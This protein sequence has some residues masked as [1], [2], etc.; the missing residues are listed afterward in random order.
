MAEQENQ[1]Q[2]H[3]PVSEQ[4]LTNI[5][6]DYDTNGMPPH[7]FWLCFQNSSP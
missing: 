1:E 3:N 2:V 7:L 4:E 6:A 5:L